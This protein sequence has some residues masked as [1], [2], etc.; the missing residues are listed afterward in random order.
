[1]NKLTELITGTC[2]S[3][4]SE[5]DPDVTLCNTFVEEYD[6]LEYGT[7]SVSLKFMSGRNNRGSKGFIAKISAGNT[8]DSVSSFQVVKSCHPHNVYL[9]AYSVQFIES[10]EIRLHI[11]QRTCSAKHFN[12]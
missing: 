5:S 8:F 4:D 12:G 2:L 1:M 7:G 11:Q 3:S 9:K 6:L 10:F